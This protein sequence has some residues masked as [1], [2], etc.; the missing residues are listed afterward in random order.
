MHS[1][2]RQPLP[3]Q[4]GRYFMRHRG[5]NLLFRSMDA[6]LRVL[7]APMRRPSV[8][9]PVRRVLIANG[10][11]LGDIVL[12]T[13]ILPVLKA[14]Y[15]DAR[16]GMLV[17]SWAGPV[18]Q[19]HALLDWVHRVD[20]WRLNRAALPL[21]AKITSWW[22]SR[23][24]A[25]REIREVEYD[26]AIDLY[27][28]FP[29]SIALLWQAG[30]PERIGYTSAGLGPLLTQPVDL[31]MREN[32]RSIVE[33]HLD[34]VRRIPGIGPLRTEL[35]VPNIPREPVDV[36]TIAGRGGYVVLHLGSGSALKDWPESAWAVLA[37][38]LL[39][40]GRRIVLTGS[41]AR[42]K[43][44]IERF[45]REVPDTV[46]LCDRLKWKEFVE[47][48]AHARLLVASDSVA[49]HIASAVGT[50]AVVTGHGMTNLH[51]WRPTSPRA[52]VLMH[53][54]PCAPCYRNAGC[55]SM[56]CLRELAPSDVRAE[57]DRLLTASTI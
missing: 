57:A 53:A 21:K 39:A 50:P 6:V 5:F 43:E 24:Q 33:L 48:I 26:V 40:E 23:R 30:I 15:P 44:K 51:L 36:E 27:F 12:S 8:P 19:G 18:V 29:N 54:V 42:E 47:V 32:R 49:A 7:R 34:L 38:Q 22:R 2:D 56:S 3:P 35:A 4:R 31:D 52:T 14:A 45:R 25:L 13:A 9:R 37:R 41:G 11:H 55:A 16:I 17:G 1:D 10:A 28:Y 20:H 46:D